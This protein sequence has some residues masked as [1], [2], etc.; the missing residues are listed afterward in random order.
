MEFGKWG[1]A[2]GFDVSGYEAMCGVVI[3]LVLKPAEQCA[4]SMCSGELFAYRSQSDIP[5]I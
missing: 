1:L 2:V 4:S 3:I 5:I